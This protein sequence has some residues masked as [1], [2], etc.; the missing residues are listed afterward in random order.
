MVTSSVESRVSG[1]ILA[2]GRAERMAGADKAALEIAGRTILDRQLAELHDLAED[3]LIVANDIARYQDR[4]ARIVPDRIAGAGALG[5]LYTALAEARCDVVLVIACDM[6]FV[7]RALLARLLTELRPEDDAVVP[8]ST[9]G[10]EPLCAV[11]RQRCAEVARAQIERGELEV[12]RLGRALRVRELGPETLA[13]YGG[14]HAFENVNT[15]HDYARARSL[16]ELTAKPSED[17]ITE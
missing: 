4:Q 17:R 1:A 6:P 2:G 5:G 13:P 7:T 3:V 14:D 8:R 15:P 16:V 9:R 12:A 11:Y 10:L